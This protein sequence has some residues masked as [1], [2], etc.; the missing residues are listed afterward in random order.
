MTLNPPVT[1]A[2]SLESW[3][4]TFGHHPWHFWGMADNNVLRVTADCAS[5]VKQYAWQEADSAGRQDIQFAIYAA[6][7]LLTEYLRFRPGAQY[8]EATM[9]WPTPGDK[10]LQRYN[11]SDPQGRWLSVPLP[12]AQLIALGVEARTLQGNAAIAY[13]DPNGDGVNELATISV[14]TTV[15]DPQEIAVYFQA[16]DRLWSDPVSEQYRIRPLTVSIAAGTATIKG[17]AYL[18]VRPV[19]Y[20]TVAPQENDI[21]LNPAD[22][23]VLAASVEVYRRYTDPNGQ[24]VTDSQGVIIWETQPCHGWWCSCGCGTPAQGSPLDPAATAQAVARVGIRS[25][26]RGV[27]IP[28]SSVYDATAGTWAAFPWSFCTPPDR[29]TVRYLAGIP[30]V[31]GDMRSDWA[32]VTARLAAAELARHICDCQ[33]SNRALDYWQKDMAITSDTESYGISPG[34]LDCPWGT[35]R[36][37]LQAWKFVQRMERVRGFTE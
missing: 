23:G 35:R 8:A 15:T 32:L 24:T 12:E 16:S 20:D 30:L 5:V 28:A 4:R 11:Y 3:R 19:N 37:H 9:P 14:V 22:A 27:V 36:G 7:K 18:F 29:V 25:A 17:P 34:D 10:R 2:L 21:D 33:Q 31:N 13:T 6:E 1:T 26:D